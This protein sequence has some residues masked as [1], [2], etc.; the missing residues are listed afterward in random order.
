MLLGS[1]EQPV[2]EADAAPRERLPWLARDAL[3]PERVLLGLDQRVA[4]LG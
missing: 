2:H 1:G 3:P 4:D